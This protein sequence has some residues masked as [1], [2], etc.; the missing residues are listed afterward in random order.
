VRGEADGVVRHG[1]GIG[2][3]VWHGAC[4]CW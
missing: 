1:D 3:G 2:E 4:E